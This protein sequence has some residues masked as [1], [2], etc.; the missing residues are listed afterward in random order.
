[1]EVKTQYGAAVEVILGGIPGAQY[2][3]SDLWKS[4]YNL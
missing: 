2:P 4:E 1:M 3:I